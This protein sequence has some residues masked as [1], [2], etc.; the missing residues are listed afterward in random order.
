MTDESSPTRPAKRAGREPRLGQVRLDPSAGWRGR[1]PGCQ[2]QGSDGDRLQRSPR[3]YLQNFRSR[4]TPLRCCASY[5]QLLED[6]ALTNANVIQL[7]KVAQSKTASAVSPVGYYH[8]F[9][10]AS[11]IPSKPDNL[12]AP[13]ARTKNKIGKT[14]VPILYTA[15]D[16]AVPTTSQLMDPDRIPNSAV[17]FFP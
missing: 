15:N 14:L 1:R 5:G 8:E 3:C 9:A 11:L 4:L 13:L 17:D 7:I 6:L 16:R 10:V 12:T 2:R